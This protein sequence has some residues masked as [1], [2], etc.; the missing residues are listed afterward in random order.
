[1]SSWPSLTVEN[2]TLQ[3]I[4]LALRRRVDAIQPL[5]SDLACES[6]HDI[7]ETSS[8]GGVPHERMDLSFTLR[9]DV[10]TKV[11]ITLYGDGDYWLRISG[12]VR[13]ASEGRLLANDP[14]AVAYAVEQT[15]RYVQR[16]GTVDSIRGLWETTHDT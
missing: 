5:V 14:T 9:S 10:P 16:D 2:E 15:L 11:L 3:Q 13:Y 6:V 7:E 4:A 1:M 8:Q 12:G